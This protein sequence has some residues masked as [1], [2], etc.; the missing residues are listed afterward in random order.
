MVFSTWWGIKTNKIANWQLYS[1]LLSFH[2]FGDDDGNDEANDDIENKEDMEED[3]N[4]WGLARYIVHMT[5]TW[6]QFYTVN[7]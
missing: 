5:T 6:G 7:G 3:E 4:T 1:V 2:G